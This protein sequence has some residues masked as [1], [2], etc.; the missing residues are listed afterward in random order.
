MEPLYEERENSVNLT[1]RQEKPQGRCDAATHTHTETL[2]SYSE[3]DPLREA[4]AEHET[5]QEM[6]NQILL[7]LTVKSLIRFKSVTKS[8]LSHISDPHFATSHLE[9]SAARTERAMNINVNGINREVIPGMI[10]SPFRFLAISSIYIAVGCQV[11]PSLGIEVSD[12][13]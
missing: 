4:G 5:P 11:G 2:C 1:D 9:L 10:L 12:H 8:W 13:V 7:R 6:I 3:L